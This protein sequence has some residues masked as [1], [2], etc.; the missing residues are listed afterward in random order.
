MIRNP[1]PVDTERSASANLLDAADAALKLHRYL[2]G[3]GNVLKG[4]DYG[5]PH[6]LDD[7]KEGR[8]QLEFIKLA[9]ASAE[10]YLQDIDSRAKRGRQARPDW[11]KENSDHQSARNRQVLTKRKWRAHE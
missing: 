1:R 8:E 3:A 9:V 7:L 5:V 11:E 4:D 2:F 10:L 6:A